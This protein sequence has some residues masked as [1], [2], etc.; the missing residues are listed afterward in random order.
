MRRADPEAWSGVVMLVVAVGMCA[1][2]LFGGYD[3]AIPRVW[4]VIAFAVMLASVLFSVFV[5]RPRLQAGSLV[6]MW[7]ASCVLVLGAPSMGL[8]VILL[9]VVAALGVYL[10]PAVFAWVI[11]ALNTVVIAVAGSLTASRPSE[12]AISTAFYL[13]VQVATVL[14]SI[15]LLREQAM[16]RQL[17]AANVELQAAGALL[18]ESARDAERLRISRDLHDSLGHQLTVLSLELEVARHRADD[19]AREHVE[20]A[21]AL[22]RSLLA[23]VRATVGELRTEPGDLR[24]VLTRIVSDLPRVEVHVEVAPQVHAG[25]QERTVIVSAVRELVTNTIR[26]ADAHELWIAVRHGDGHL[27]LTAADD[28]AG[29]VEFEPGNGLRGLT[30]RFESLGGDV[31]VD[32]TR[33]FRVTARVPSP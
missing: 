23:D 10:V 5:Q 13:L 6:A 22:A 19:G 25:E 2:V 7:I 31:T 27:V 9:V 29:A 14:S 3:P 11:V 21:H 20:R 32:P 18:A 26:H 33:G 1:P 8:L 30:E 15:T 24:D 28:G 16:R 12:V 17:A 4:W